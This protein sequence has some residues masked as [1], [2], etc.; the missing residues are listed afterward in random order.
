MN[1]SHPLADLLGENMARIIQ[2]LG[3][4]HT[5]L[6]GR[7]IAEL[8][9]VPVASASRVLR[10]LE[11][12]GLVHTEDVGPSRVY[13]LNREHVL[14]NPL[15]L[16]VRSPA[17]IK[18]AMAQLAA[19]AAD[20]NTTVAVFGSFARGEGGAESD[21][22]VVIV[23]GAN[24]SEQ[25]RFELADS[26]HERIEEMTGNRLDIIEVDD[27]HLARMAASEDPL[28]DSWAED[29]RTVAG[30]DLIDRIRRARVQ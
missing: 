7:R 1:L 27:E 4:V 17:I 13:R 6:S 10:R 11:T 29:G 30:P 18:Q 21:I 5:G 26:L 8:A 15:D 20:A 19:S 16:M 24:A 12:M 22:D 28:L 25:S 14:W 9:E 2:R 3:M 23:N